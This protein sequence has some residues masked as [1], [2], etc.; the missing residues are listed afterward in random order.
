MVPGQRLLTTVWRAG[1]AG[2]H[3]R[4]ACEATDP[5]GTVVIRHGW[6]EIDGPEGGART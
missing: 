1:R 6:A 3:V 2:A 4:Y 5:A